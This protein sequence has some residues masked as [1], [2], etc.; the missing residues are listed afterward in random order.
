MKY[1]TY[2]HTTPD[3][4]VFYVGKGTGRRVYS[5]RDR[6]LKWREVVEEHAG[7]TMKIVARFATEQEAFAHEIELISMYKA[8]GYELVNLTSGGRGPL[9]YCS[10]EESRI[11]KRQQMTGYKH[12]KITCPHCGTSGGGTSIKRWHFDN[13]KGV[14]PAYKARIT[15]LGKR[16]YLGKYH[17]QSEANATSKEF[18]DFVME[19]YTTLGRK[20]SDSIWY[21]S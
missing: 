12:K 19:E 20:P 6:T 15:V 11:L 1:Y 16:V 10:S 13:C 17:T 18:Y 3:G 8:A 4:I 14:R 21:I 7:V 5:M 9:D 2:I